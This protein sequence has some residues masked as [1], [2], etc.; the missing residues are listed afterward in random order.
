MVV[1]GHTHNAYNCQLP[2]SAD[3][4]IPVSSAASFGRLV[5]DIDMKINTHSGRPMSISVN[6]RIVF[7][8]TADADETALVN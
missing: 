3:V 7:R 5:T 6:N 1:S 8:D 4:P 2:N